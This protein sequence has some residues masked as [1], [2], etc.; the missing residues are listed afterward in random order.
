MRAYVALVWTIAREDL[1]LEFRTYERPTEVGGLVVFVRVVF[2]FS[3]DAVGV[4]P[5]APM[6]GRALAWAAA[7]HQLAFGPPDLGPV[8]GQPI[9]GGTI[10]GVIACNLSGPRRP[11]A[12]AARDHVL[13]IR[14]VSGRGEVFASGGRGVKNVTGYAMSS[15]VTG[16][17]GPLAVL[18]LVA[19]K[20]LPRAAGRPVEGAR[21]RH[22]GAR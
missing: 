19:L 22:P 7:G 1:L 15:L 2:K 18:S 12:G 5:A 6:D 10:G 4:G 11:F 17:Y 9:G 13:G 14:A 21:P 20:G 16:S 3:V 8:Y